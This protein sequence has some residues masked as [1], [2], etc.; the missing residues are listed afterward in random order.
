MLDFKEVCCSLTSDWHF[1]IMTYKKLLK[2]F[3]LG[4][5]SFPTQSV[6]NAI[7]FFCWEI[8]KTTVLTLQQGIITFQLTWRYFTTHQNNQDSVTKWVSCFIAKW[9]C[10]NWLQRKRNNLDFE[11]FPQEFLCILQ[12]VMENKLTGT[13]NWEF[14]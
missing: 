9:L 3:A 14:I 12:R 7:F 6:G 5:R 2:Q 1:R 13:S 8:L 11:P 4:L 10:I